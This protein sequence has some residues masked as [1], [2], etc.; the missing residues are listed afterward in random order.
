MVTLPSGGNAPRVLT[1]LACDGIDPFTD[2][3]TS[4]WLNGELGRASDPDAGA[5]TNDS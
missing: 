3:A 4:G 5:N 2:K 1:C